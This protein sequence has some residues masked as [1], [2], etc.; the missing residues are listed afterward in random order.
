[1][2]LNGTL[3]Y[4]ESDALNLTFRCSDTENL[5]D[6]STIVVTVTADNDNIPH[7]QSSNYSFSVDRIDLPSDHSIGQ[8]T[9]EDGDVGYGGAITYS[10]E[11]NS[12]FGIDAEDGT[13]TL[14]GHLLA[15][16]VGSSLE[17]TVQVSDGEY[18]DTATVSISVSGPLSV[19]DIILLEAGFVFLLLLCCLFCCC[20]WFYRKRRINR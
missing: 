3:D 1:M 15:V 7:F 10:I 9:A 5:E 8:V 4:D 6:F 2:F 19:L 14:T 13:V 11:S 12:Y 16:E 20:L 18:T 17:L